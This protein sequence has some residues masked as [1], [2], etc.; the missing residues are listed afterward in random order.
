MSLG[1]DLAIVL[2]V[3]VTFAIVMIR[4]FIKTIF[5]L[6]S[7]VFAII[8]AKM[9]SATVSNMFYDF[10]YK[11][12]S[13]TVESVVNKVLAN[14]G[15]SSASKI[16]NLLALL[17][18]YNPSLANSII[19]NDINDRF[20]GVVQVIVGLLSY[21]ISFLLIFIVSLFVFKVLSTVLSKIFK[22]PILNVI[23]KTLSF[24]LAV[25]MCFVYVNLFV[26]F[27]QIIT[28]ALSSVYPNLLDL[29]VVEQTF[30]FEYFY[31]FKWIKFLVN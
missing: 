11:H 7:V 2:I 8:L 19:G 5:D 16:D 21:A 30:I 31:N 6:V 9:F 27:M 3:V 20:H 28:P 29:E 17:G 24:V 10:L 26:A 23:N 1:L 25:L 13:N 18:D 22:L 14:D 12:F 15:I 4:G